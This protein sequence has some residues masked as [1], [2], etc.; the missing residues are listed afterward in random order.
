MHDRHHACPH[1][2]SCADMHFLYYILV[3][4]ILSFFYC[5]GRFFLNN[6]INCSS[7]CYILVKFILSFF[8]IEL[9]NL[10]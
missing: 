9:H 2:E 5:N 8:F 4:F 1:D 10:K 3:K 6:A 7:M